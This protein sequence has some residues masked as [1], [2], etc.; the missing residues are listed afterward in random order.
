ML[1]GKWLRH[2][3]RPATQQG[4]VIVAG[5]QRSGTNMVMNMLERHG[6]TQVFHER[7]HRAYHEYI[8][9]DLPV[10]LAL[11]EQCRAPYFVIKALCE[12][13][14]LE[15]L[16]DALSP[17]RVLWVY[18]AWPDVVNSMV[19]S[20]GGFERHLQRIAED[21]SS[22]GWR[23]QGMTDATHAI[24]REVAEQGPDEQSAAA[25][26]WFYRNRLYFD[27]G[28]DRDPRVQLLSYEKLVTDPSTVLPVV[29][30]RLCLP[31]QPDMVGNLTP[32]SVGKNRQPA[33]MGVVA[34][35]CDTL[36]ARF[37]QADS[38]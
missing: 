21:R 36:Y 3:L 25:L 28:Y 4:T 8:M 14:R 30:E 33:V 13:H 10:I 24:V 12:L 1:S 17:A 2:R 20:F 31:F 15:E 16:M 34:Q 7:D 11:H 6:A 29:C 26:Q 23:G 37:E 32:A 18:R 27:L 22:A 9:R 35:L 5:S 38:I 19:R